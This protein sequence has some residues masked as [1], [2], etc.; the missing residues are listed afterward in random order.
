MGSL[1]LP[2][3]AP[4]CSRPVSFDRLL[5]RSGR[6]RRRAVRTCPASTCTVMPAAFRGCAQSPFMTAV[7]VIRLR[8]VSAAL[9]QSTRRPGGDAEFEPATK[10]RRR[11]RDANSSRGC[12][13]TAL[14][15]GLSVR[16][17]RIRVGWRASVRVHAERPVPRGRSCVVVRLSRLAPSVA[18]APLSSTGAGPSARERITYEVSAYGKNRQGGDR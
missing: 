16:G 12:R 3:D 18:V 13:R 6:E 17:G 15:E 10:H 4:S 2:C 9:P 5:R 7:S 8:V 14:N 1:R 11:N